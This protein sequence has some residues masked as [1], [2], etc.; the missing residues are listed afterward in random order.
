MRLGQQE[1]LL[2]SLSSRTVRR[3]ALIVEVADDRPV[4]FDADH[5]EFVRLPAAPAG[6][7]VRSLSADGTRL[8]LTDARDDLPGRGVGV[9]DLGGG[10]VRWFAGA[11]PE[12]EHDV[13]AMFAPDGTAIAVLGGDDGEEPGSAVVSLL[14]PA[15]G[16]RHRVWTA[17][18]TANWECGLCWSPRGDLLA[19]TYLTWDEEHDDDM[20]CTVVID[21]GT[22]KSLATYPNASIAAATGAG[23]T[24][25]Q[26]LVLGLEHDDLN[27][28]QVADPRTGTVR[29]TAE[30][31][32]RLWGVIGRRHLQQVAAHEEPDA[33]ATIFYTGD[34]DGADRRPLF[35]CRP[36]VTVERVHL[37]PQ[38][39]PAGTGT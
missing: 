23:W 9:L 36:R 34:L 15:S 16:A 19:V 24:E 28:R 21:P 13:H 25:E 37:A 27:R 30:L 20:L 12:F 14:D 2:E 32:G 26:E 4:A 35:T 39:F 31:T 22:G 18:G 11:D 5:Q 33:P 7:I 17:E 1:F 6:T 38:A 29:T 3:A 8:L 10:E